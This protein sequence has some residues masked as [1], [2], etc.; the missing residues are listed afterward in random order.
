MDRKPIVVSKIGAD[1]SFQGINRQ[2]F[3]TMFGNVK[4]SL[5][6]C[7]SGKFSEIGVGLFA[8]A[9]SKRS[10]ITAANF[11]HV[12]YEEM[13]KLIN[14]LR[15]N[16]MDLFNN[17]CFT[18]LAVV[19]TETDFVVFT[20]GDG[21][22]FLVTTSN[23]LDI[24]DIDDGYNNYPPY[25]VYNFIKPENLSDYKNGVRFN[26]MTFSKAGYQNVGV[27]SD[28]YRFIENLENADKERFKEAILEGKP[29][30]IG[31]IINRNA[32]VFKDDITIVL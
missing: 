30:R 2:D 23:E 1:H 25:F 4:L 7:S 22:I 11:D 10:D 21:Y 9:L 18:I 15:F 13:R 28:G 14:G 26:V 16:D 3:G 27:A 12:V 20:C 31:Q 32:Q 5:D 8:Q 19:E 6:G 29:G 24:I 17:F